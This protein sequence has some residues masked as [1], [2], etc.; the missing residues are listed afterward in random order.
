[1]NA[2]VIINISNQDQEL[3]VAFEAA[4]K[5]RKWQTFKKV[6]LAYFRP[7]EKNMNIRDIEVS[8]KR[9]VEDS[10]FESEWSKL[11]YMLLVSDSKVEVLVSK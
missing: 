5:K 4:M 8:V 10:V 3:V 1:M 2:I 6:P 7:C 9:D 11:N